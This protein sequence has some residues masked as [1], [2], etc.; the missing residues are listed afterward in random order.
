MN[1]L[2]LQS[3]LAKLGYS[4]QTK[5]TVDAD[6]AAVDKTI[7]HKKLDSS[8]GSELDGLALEIERFVDGDKDRLVLSSDLFGS[9]KSSHAISLEDFKGNEPAVIEGVITAAERDAWARPDN[10]ARTQ[11]SAAELQEAVEAAFQVE[12]ERFG[13][14]YMAGSVP[15]QASLAAVGF[16]QLADTDPEADYFYRSLDG[17]THA[18]KLTVSRTGACELELLQLSE[19]G[20]PVSLA[21]D[22][23]DNPSATNIAMLTNAQ[24]ADAGVHRDALVLRG[25]AAENTVDAALRGKSANQGFY[26]VGRN[27]GE[28]SGS[29]YARDL[30]GGRTQHLRFPDDLAKPVIVETRDPNGRPETDQAGEVLVQEVRLDRGSESKDDYSALKLVA[31]IQAAEAQRIALGTKV[32]EPVPVTKNRALHQKRVQELQ[33][34]VSLN[35]DR[36]MLSLSKQLD[37]ATSNAVN[38]DSVFGAFS[39]G[40]QNAERAREERLAQR[41]SKVTLAAGL[42]KK[43]RE[44]AGLETS[45]AED[46]PGMSIRTPREGFSPERGTPAN[47][48]RQVVAIHTEFVG[49]SEQFYLFKIEGKNE[50]IAVPLKD[51]TLP[52]DGPS[53]QVGDKLAVNWNFKDRAAS[54]VRR[55]LEQKRGQSRQVER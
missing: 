48:S 8:V 5:R 47:P 38:Q 50:A 41:A 53:L 36:F 1:S 51:L 23:L 15:V 21:K 7:F 27:E 24:L 20:K 43:G 32:H 14:D 46:Y 18:Q 29:N 11:T 13:L 28:P 39:R 12:H 55:E 4:A 54:I 16:R 42:T 34:D 22:H 44:L 35:H 3:V 10:L 33:V 49:R 40:Y 19:G 6:G 2:E 52:Q 30:K 31:A 9:L 25:D 45:L 17:G 37:Y 26:S